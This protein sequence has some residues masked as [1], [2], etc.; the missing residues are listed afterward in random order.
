MEPNGN[1][2]PQSK[3]AT[4]S[5]ISF[6]GKAIP[7]EYRS[8]VFS[9]WMRTLRYGNEY[10][11]LTESRHYFGAYQKYIETL[12]ARPGAVVRLAVIT[13]D[14]DVVLGW[15][16]MDGTTL[17]YV[18]VQK[19]QRNKGVGTI[20]VPKYIESISHLTKAGLSIWNKKYP[21]AKFNPFQ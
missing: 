9:Q 21:H 18:H 5:V 17:H 4:Y 7:D 6:S 20:L 16:L 15:S 11:K 8:L 3:E 14:R 2:L 10:F 1:D 19:D 13:D 12:L